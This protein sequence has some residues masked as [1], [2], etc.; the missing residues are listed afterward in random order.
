MEIFLT[1]YII[2]IFRKKTDNRLDK[3]EEIVIDGSVL[4]HTDETQE[5]G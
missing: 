2:Q 4:N 3:N 1:I 5:S